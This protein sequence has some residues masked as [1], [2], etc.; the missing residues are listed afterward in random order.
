VAA[1]VA[2]EAGPSARCGDR[3]FLSMLVCMKRECESASLRN[4][5]E[6]VKMREQ[7]EASRNTNR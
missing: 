5:P 2:V 3:N 6:C 4:H 7:E 1:A